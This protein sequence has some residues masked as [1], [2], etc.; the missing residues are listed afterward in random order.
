MLF[1]DI[2]KKLIKIF[3]VIMDLFFMINIQEEMYVKSLTGRQI[4]KV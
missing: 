3:T 1:A 2:E 4:K